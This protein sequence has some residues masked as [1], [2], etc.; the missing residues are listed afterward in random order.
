LHWWRYRFFS[1]GRRS[2]RARGKRWVSIRVIP[3]GKRVARTGIGRGSRVDVTG[4]NGSPWM[5]EF[6]RAVPYRLP[7]RAAI[8]SRPDDK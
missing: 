5:Q 1:Q 6:G 7:E 8:P 4:G 2:T 3:F